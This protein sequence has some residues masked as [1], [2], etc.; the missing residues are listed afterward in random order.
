MVPKS[1]GSSKRF[2]G[3]N[4]IT[5]LSTLNHWLTELADELVER[6]N[7]DELEN[8]RFA[9][10]LT[11]TF[12]QEINGE[13]IASTRVF[14]LVAYNVERIAKDA[15][16]VIQRN[17]EVFLTPGT[18]A[19]KNPIKLL[20]VSAGKFEDYKGEK[21]KN[22]ETFFSTA[23]KLKELS[24]GPSITPYKSITT[25]PE[26][27]NNKYSMKLS[28]F[29][30]NTKVPDK[31]EWNENKEI[32]EEP[33]KDEKPKSAPNLSSFISFIKNK[34]SSTITKPK[35]L[36]VEE[37]SEELFEADDLAEVPHCSK[38]LKLETIT[39][40]QKETDKC[41]A[42]AENVEGKKNEDL[43]QEEMEIKKEEIEEVTENVKQI[44]DFKGNQ[45]IPSSPGSPDHSADIKK[46][47][48]EDEEQK[49]E[50]LEN[51]V[52][53]FE[54]EN[55]ETLKSSHDFDQGESSRKQMDFTKNYAEFHIP[56]INSILSEFTEICEECGKRISP[57]NKIEHM[58]QH[59]AFKLS[60]QLREEYRNELKIV[61]KPAAPKTTKSKSNENVKKSPNS[62]NKVTPKVPS[63]INF[64]QKEKDEENDAEKIK[65]EQCNVWI[66]VDKLE[67]HNDFHFAKNILMLEKSESASVK[68]DKSSNNTSTNST[69]NNRS[70]KKRPLSV[71]GN[72]NNTSAKQFKAFFQK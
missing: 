52:M 55:E 25:S 57:L 30:S 43:K 26:S 20:G 36:E 48:S 12:T 68:L 11:A 47:N 71:Q 62:S 32:K 17:S 22:I 8:N 14:P 56:E 2:P 24:E 54:Y 28:K 66:Q 44:H 16:E 61:K 5:G 38:D 1:I 27:G 37:N 49:I 46:L 21:S 29:I 4:A 6:L 65:C 9:K 18:T 69:N 67:E 59:L 53:Q 35:T 34:P 60:Q 50:D 39:E 3:R 63:V 31:L 51:S 7:K 45:N 10:Q 40:L 58:D 42:R 41:E 64:F 13:D 70:S 23:K 72:Q 19:L 33:T 15:L